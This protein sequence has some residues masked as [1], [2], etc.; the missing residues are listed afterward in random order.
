MSY[1]EGV[2]ASSK[3][4]PSVDAGSV[5][6]DIEL[7]DP[8]NIQKILAE[9]ISARPRLLRLNYQL[10]E[11]KVSP[12]KL[13]RALP[14]EPNFYVIRGEKPRRKMPRSRES[15]VRQVAGQARPGVLN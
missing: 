12:N 11:E 4:S 13:K 1:S 9:R 15:V 2:P 6:Y 8:A 3:K 14:A 5:L 7:V 10:W